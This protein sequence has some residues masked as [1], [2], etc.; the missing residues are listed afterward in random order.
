[1]DKMAIVSFRK[2]GAVILREVFKDWVE[3]LRKGVAKNMQTPGPHV[4]VYKGDNPAEG[5][6][7]FFG[8]Y[9]NWQ[10]IPEYSDFIFNS[11]IGEM[12]SQLMGSKTVRLFHEHV[13][14]KEA[15]TELVTPWHQDQPYYCVEAS[16][17]ISFWIPLDDVPRERSPEFVAGSHGWGKFFS[18]E[19]FNGRPLNK[20]DDLE[21]MPDIEAN[22]SNYD[23]LSWE[24]SI[25]DA[26][27]F[28]FST[29]HGAPSN[30]STSNSRRAFSLRL[31]G[32]E[33]RF[34]RTPGY[35]SSPPFTDIQLKNG[36]LLDEVS[37]PELYRTE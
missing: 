19:R 17:N 2:H 12:A 31:V 32:D 3:I 6:G 7:K 15:K 30:K 34:K 1:M 16:Q 26:I 11:R 4:R 33:A 10:R 5:S 9:C 13:L 29:V 21:K 28:D 22:R 36:A 8:D 24:L 20:G 35:V 14:V 23:I 37:F 25:G 27:A 18:P